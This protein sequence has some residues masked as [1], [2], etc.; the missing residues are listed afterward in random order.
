LRILEDSWILHN[1]QLTKKFCEF[2]D[3]EMATLARYAVDICWASVDVKEKIYSEIDA[4]VKKFG[5]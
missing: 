2:N 3:G 4:V 5:V 1:Y